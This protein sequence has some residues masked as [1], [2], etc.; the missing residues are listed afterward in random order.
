MHRFQLYAVIL[1]ACTLALSLIV[2]HFSL[3]AIGLVVFIF[4]VQESHKAKATQ[5][6][7]VPRVPKY[8]YQSYNNYLKSDKWKELRYTILVRDSHTCQDCKSTTNLQVHHLH[9]RGID[10]MTF[11]S[12]QLVTV[13]YDC[14]EI[15]HS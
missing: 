13:C 8:Y 6:Y 11:T 14:H 4:W 9:Y 1:I 7:R 12:D 2:P 15:R 3:I 10:T 5:N